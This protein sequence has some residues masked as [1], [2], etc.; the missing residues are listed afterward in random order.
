[1]QNK[2]LI[3][4]LI[5]TLLILL[6]PYNISHADE[7]VIQSDLLNVRTGPGTEYDKITQ[8]NSGEIYQI[9]QTDNDWVEIKLENGSGWITDEYITINKSLEES[10]ITEDDTNQVELTDTSS[11]VITNNNTH[12]RSGPSTEYDIIGFSEKNEEYDLVTAENEWFEIEHDGKAGFIFK[13]LLNK[14]QLKKNITFKNKLIVIDAGHGGH[15]V[16]SIGASGKYES[17]LTY[18]TTMELKNELALLGAEVVLTRESNDYVRLS[19]R[20]ALSNLNTT[21]AFISIHYNSFPEQSSV[22]G[23]NS[24]YYHNQNKNLASY[25]QQ[26]IIDAT[27][28]KDRGIAYGDFQVLR[29]N[30]KPAVLLEL[31]FIS[32]TEREQL[33]LTNAYQKKLVKGIINGLTQYFTE[34]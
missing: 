20:S 9:L 15:D 3:T 1:M 34:K 24:Y 30:Y 5:F 26:G 17:D 7:A 25:I 29:T 16:G 10:D 23:I 22:T 18:K 2:F 14:K 12:I 32:N 4:G 31:D 19:S 8:I 28:S 13:D 11:L 21:D 27:D 6:I 33:L